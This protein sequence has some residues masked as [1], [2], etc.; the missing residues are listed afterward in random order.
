[1]MLIKLNFPVLLKEVTGGTVKRANSL[2]NF[3][4]YAAQKQHKTKR[5]KLSGKGNRCE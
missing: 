4:F 3:K 1:M 2:K 5:L